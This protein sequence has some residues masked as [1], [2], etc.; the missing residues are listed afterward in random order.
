M[1]DIPSRDPI[2]ISPLWPATV[3]WD[4]KPGISEYW[5]VSGEERVLESPERP[6]PQIIPM[7]IVLEIPALDSFVLR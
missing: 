7:L 2:T 6:E 4:G 3:V 5:I 1:V